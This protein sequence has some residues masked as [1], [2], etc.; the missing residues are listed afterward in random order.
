MIQPTSGDRIML[1][2]LSAMMV[3]FIFCPAAAYEGLLHGEMKAWQKGIHL[4][5]GVGLNVSS[6]KIDSEEEWFGLGSNFKADVAWLFNDTWAI[7]SSDSIK[8]NRTPSYLYW[9][10]LFT[11]G[12]KYRLQK[13][14]FAN[15]GNYVRLFVGYAPTVVYPEGAQFHPDNVDRILL[16]GPVYGFGLGH[17]FSTAT[18]TVWFFEGNASVQ[19]LRRKNAIAMDGQVPVVVDTEAIVGNSTIYS[20][21]VTLGLLFF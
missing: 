4:F 14:L 15:V 3:L 7:E 2:I 20:V 18:G 9:D 5:A 12:V 16:E 17:L 11:L 13:T 8:F 21:Y 1:K 19:Y 10:T 6:Y